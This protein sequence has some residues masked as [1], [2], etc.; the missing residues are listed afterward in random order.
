[1]AEHRQNYTREIKH[2]RDTGF[3]MLKYPNRRSVERTI[4]LVNIHNL[5]PGH[6][7]APETQH[8]WESHRLD[9]KQANGSWY[10]SI[11]NLMFFDPHVDE[12]SEYLS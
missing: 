7:L 6:F 11:G 5:P 8:P 4:Q 2:R 3:Y 10:K 9:C 12:R 1:M